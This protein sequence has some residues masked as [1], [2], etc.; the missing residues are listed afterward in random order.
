[1]KAVSHQDSAN[2]FHALLCPIGY[3]GLYENRGYQPVIVG[4]ML[5]EKAQGVQS[6]GI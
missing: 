1:M 5:G 2:S 3:G 4:F 6:P